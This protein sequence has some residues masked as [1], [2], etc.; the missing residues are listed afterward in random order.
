MP[1]SNYFKKSITLLAM[2]LGFFMII[3]DT[4]VV[5]VALPSI[6]I[7][8]K[9]NTSGVQWVVG[10]YTISFASLL[11]L[12][13]N[14]ADRFSAKSV[15]M[16]GLVGFLVTSLG[17]G[18]S[19]N[20]TSLSLWRL[21][22]GAT[23]TLLIPA[24]LNIIKQVFTEKK[25]FAKAIGIWGGV[26][27]LASAS[28]PVIGSALT[29]IF[30]W[31]AIFFVNAPIALLALLLL[32]GTIHQLAQST[33]KKAYDWLGQ[34]FAIV[35]TISL[36]AVL[37]ESGNYSWTSPLIISISVIAI[38]SLIAFI[39]IESYAKHPILPLS[40][41][42]SINFSTAMLIGFI[43]N[44]GAY[45][46]LFLLPLYFSRVRNYSI[47]EVG[48]AVLPF[49]ILSAIASYLSGNALTRIG[50]RKSVL[51]GL[52]VGAIGFLFL[53]VAISSHLAYYWLIIPLA[54]IGFGAAFT[55][56]SAT[57]II[58]HSVHDDSSGIASSAFTTARQIGSLVGVALFG[59]LFSTSTSYTNGIVVTLIIASAMYFTG[60]LMSQR[61]VSQY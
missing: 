26:A 59:T 38:A 10:A 13:G 44:C 34:L 9:T 7:A 23:A 11:L 42:K 54:S 41:F 49:L 28:G 30:S 16:A 29:A 32:H 36:A 8:L 45:G 47:T 33:K 56:P 17:C 12:A 39:I 15:L 3:L 21:L 2:C 46:Q 55:M 60:S 1:H 31:R 61:I 48:F 14:L 22:Q 25:E 52:T 35:F 24:S 58:I 27:G 40:F 18:F 20:I 57:Y 50:A 4:T 19:T 43:I 51:I 5:N 6:T 53:S 37:I